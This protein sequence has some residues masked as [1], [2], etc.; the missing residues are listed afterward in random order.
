[1]RRAVGGTHRVS[2]WTIGLIEMV[3]FCP[4]VVGSLSEGAAGNPTVAMIV[5]ART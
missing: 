4:A 5:R 2:G 1:M 3:D